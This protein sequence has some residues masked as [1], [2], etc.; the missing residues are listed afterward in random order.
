MHIN[1]KVTIIINTSIAIN[2]A[3]EILLLLL[4]I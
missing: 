1:K 3:T 2:L 4:F